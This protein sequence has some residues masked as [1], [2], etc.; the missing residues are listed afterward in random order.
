MKEINQIELRK[1]LCY[2]PL[3]GNFMWRVSVNRRIRIGSIAGSVVRDRR[4]KSYTHIKI[5][6]QS[7]LAHRLAFLYIKGR[8]PREIDHKDGKGLNNKWLN[9]R[10]C[11][12]SQNAAN[13]GP[14]KDNKLGVKGVSYY[15]GSGK[16]VAQI[17]IYGKKT[18]LGYFNTVEAATRAY[19]KA[20][21]KHYG[22]FTP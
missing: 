20:A 15:S 19:K 12:H 6:G 7:Y 5:H 9:L 3:S 1:L 18:H 11:T 14:R 17:G 4:G 22:E 16:Y 2:N 21:K 10:E 8:W 13:Q